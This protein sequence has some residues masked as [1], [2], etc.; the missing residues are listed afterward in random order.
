MKRTFDFLLY[1]DG[2][3]L[4]GM[5]CSEP[6]SYE[7]SAPLVISA[8]ERSTNTKCGSTQGCRRA[9]KILKKLLTSMILQSS[10]VVPQLSNLS[11][12]FLFSTNYLK[13]SGWGQFS[14][15][16]FI[17]SVNF[18]RNSEFDRKNGSL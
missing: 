15:A 10:E 9:I 14:N 11:P 16:D 12:T 17:F 6:E 4:N 2:L 8:I 3:T 18:V 5:G 7:N 13:F 1:L